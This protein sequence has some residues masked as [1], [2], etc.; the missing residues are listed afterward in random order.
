MQTIADNPATVKPLRSYQTDAIRSVRDVMG[1]GK[2]R[3]ILVCPTGGGKTRIGAEVVRS[4]M[5]RGRRVLW[6]AHRTELIEQTCA[7][8]YELGLRVGAIAASSAWPIDIEAPVQVCSIQTLLARAHRPPADLIVWD[9][10]HHAGEAAEEWYSLLNSYDRIHML[11]LTATPERGDGTGLAPPFEAIVLAASTR[12]L[13]QEGW[14][15]PC[16][17]VRPDTLLEPNHIAQHPLEAYLKSS[18]GQQAILF[19]RS[20]KEAQQY[21]SEF[22]VG[23]IRAACVH[24]K[25][26]AD[27]RATIVRGF[28]DGIIRVLTNVYVFTEGTDLPMAQCCILARG[29]STPGAYLQMVGRILRPAPRKTSA[30]LLDLRG[31]S[32]V[33][34]MPEDER[35]YRLTGK[36]IVIAGSVCKV[37]GQP[38]DGYPCAAC[39]YM[40]DAGEGDDLATEIDQVPINKYAR[41]IAEGP[42]QRYETAV[43]WIKAALTKGHKPISVMYKWKAVYGERMP[44]D[45][46]LR[47]LAE[48][49][50]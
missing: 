32:H 4:A 3:V 31:I 15:V 20:V 30:T 11:G 46:F 44:L 12:R 7:T 17:V 39:N 49:S 34:G 28:R 13:T 9:E 27:E 40:P 43:R 10:C 19:A 23:G 47:A 1:T 5:A 33:H 42:Q 36:A 35:V 25:T 14:L 8:L 26:P 16:E 24:A 22:C 45:L 38:I 41:K 2:R 37:C 48:A 6:I 18:P 50:P 21:A 29:A